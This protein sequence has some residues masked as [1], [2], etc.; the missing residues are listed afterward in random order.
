[1]RRDRRRDEG[2]AAAVQKAVQN[3]GPIAGPNAGPNGANRPPTWVGFSDTTLRDGEQAPA[4][5]FT[6]SEKL[7]IARTL[8]ALGVQRIEAGAPIMGGPEARALRA[9]G[10]AG[11]AAR[12]VA[13]CRADRAD[14][15]AA[16]RCGLV[17]V[18]TCIPVSAEHVARKFRRDLVWARRH[19]LDVV[20]E[21]QDRNLRVSVGFEDA[22]R[23]DDA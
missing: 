12:V 5:A 21:A 4:V 10:D 17:D 23:A 7:A 15:D 13:W 2:G 8:D 14:L 3:A 9:I 1:M 16:E 19:I 20:A 11:L 18:H 22:S 6:V